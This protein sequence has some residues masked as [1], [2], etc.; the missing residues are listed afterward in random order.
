M[1]L[2]S[3][4]KRTEIIIIYSMRNERIYSPH[5]QLTS[6]KPGCLRDWARG[7]NHG[8]E[9]CERLS[10]FMAAIRAAHLPLWRELP[11]KLLIGVIKKLCR[12]L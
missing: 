11:Q 2:G 7:G 1:S 6:H 8:G 12:V 5:F 10:S 3:V 4:E 9:T